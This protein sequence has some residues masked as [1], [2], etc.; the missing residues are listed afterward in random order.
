[1]ISYAGLNMTAEMSCAS[2]GLD[3]TTNATPNMAP[4]VGLN[5][6]TSVGLRMTTDVGLAKG[7][8][9]QVQKP[10]ELIW[11][12]K[13]MFSTLCLLSRATPSRLPRC[14]RMPPARKLSF[15]HLGKQRQKCK[16]PP[17]FLLAR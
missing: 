6:I 9:P 17:G 7:I 4:N 13:R 3:M 14:S 8:R 11:V 15:V 1:M 10:C 5:F 12:S 2:L 16:F